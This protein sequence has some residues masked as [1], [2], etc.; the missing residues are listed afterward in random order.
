MQVSVELP[1]ALAAQAA[2]QGDLAGW[3]VE[4]ARVHLATLVA[5]GDVEL[6]GPV[7]RALLGDIDRVRFESEFLA[8]VSAA[9]R[10]RDTDR[11]GGV[12]ASWW[13]AAGGD[14][15]VSR[16]QFA[17]AWRGGHLADQEPA[18]PRPSFA[19]SKIVNRTPLAILSVLDLGGR[20]EF[21]TQLEAAL[22]DAAATFDHRGVEALVERWWVQ[23]MIRANPGQLQVDPDELARV[24]EGIEPT[25]PYRAA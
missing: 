21:D 25:F 17:R 24:K 2:A 5:Q 22:D 1:D 13:E 3:L 15:G 20:T 10:D 16:E 9:A 23:V 6:S 12:V 11:L 19:P 18:E 4:A 14:L 8:A 7:V